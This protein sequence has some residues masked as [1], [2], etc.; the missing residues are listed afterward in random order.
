[1]TCKRDFG[2]VIASAVSEIAQEL[3]NAPEPPSGEGSERHLRTLLRDH[4]LV[5]E[6]GWPSNQILYGELYDIYGHD[7]L[8]YVVVYVETKTPRRSRL[9]AE[10][11]LDFEARMKRLGTCEY[12]MITNGHQLISYEVSLV[13]SKIVVQR[14]CEVDLD[15]VVEQVRNGDLSIENRDKLEQAFEQLRPEKYLKKSPESYVDEYGRINPVKSEKNSMKALSSQLSSAIDVLSPV[16]AE[17]LRVYL[18]SKIQ[19]GLG[20]QA[21]EPLDDWSTY[22]GRVPPST[23]EK[24]VEESVKEL[25]ALRAKGRINDVVL[26][27]KERDAR[28]KLGLAISSSSWSKL[29]ADSVASPEQVQEII[30]NSVLDLI[31]EDH[32]EVFA[33][34][35]SHV[36]LSRILLYRVAEDKGLVERKLSGR[37]LDS[38]LASTGSGLLDRTKKAT[39]IKVLVEEAEELL[40]SVFYSDLYLHGLF[41]WWVVP[42]EVREKYS[43]QYRSIYQRTSRS[44][45]V[46]LE[47]TIRILNRFRLDS[48]ERDVWKD[49]YQE[50]LPAK[51]RAKLGGFYTPDEVVNLI[52][53]LVGYLPQSPICG[54]TLLDPACGSGTFVV[55][56]GNR[57]RAHLESDCECHREISSVREPRKRA[58]LI[59]QKMIS[60]LYALDIHPFACF[61]TEMNFVLSTVDLLMNARQLDL[62][63]RIEELNVGCDDSLRPAERHIHQLKLSQFAST[64]SRAQ[65]LIRDRRKA[66]AIKEAS[67]D[68]VVGNPPWSGV[69][70]GE[71]SPLFDEAT[72]QLYKT[73]YVSATDKYDLYVLFVERGIRWLNRNGRLGLI[74]QN[75]FARRR[76]GRGLRSLIKEKSGSLLYCIDMART[77]KVVFPGQT[78][79]PW[80]TVLQMNRGNND[81]LFAETKKPLFKLTLDELVSEIKHGLEQAE[82]NQLYESDKI[83][84]YPLPQTRIRGNPEE[85]W[86][87]SSSGASE[88]K[89]KIRSTRKSHH[90]SQVLELNQG[91]T[92]GGGCLDVFLTKSPGSFEPELVFPCA[93]A[94]DIVCWKL[95]EPHKWIVYPYRKDGSSVNLG[96]I[97]LDL[98]QDQAHAEIDGLIAR[99]SIKYPKVAKFLVDRY[100][101]LAS[102]EAEKMSWKDYGKAW[103]EYHRPRSPSLMMESPKILTRRMTHDMEF[104]LDDRGFIPTDGCIALTLTKNSNWIESMREQGFDDRDSLCFCLALLNSE[105]VKFLVRNSADSW[106]GEYYQVREDT[107]ADVPVK[108]PSKVDKAMF[109]GVIAAVKGVLEGKE[110]PKA[111]NSEILRLYG[112]EGAL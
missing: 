77:G 65:L 99:G 41:D 101:K 34:Q 103:Y 46:A 4:L 70:R 112:L 63:F 59:L 64:N 98:S 58:K 45:D 38:Y 79:Y 111:A 105:I 87:M 49:V 7:L 72:K 56:A 14:I 75:R 2:E 35:T 30:E 90:L 83:V 36:I 44:I 17:T 9:T 106:Q 109:E 86:D 37:P 91:V 67:F 82:R 53:D 8:G 73:L 29:I 84:A 23:I 19:I 27:R 15:Q 20:F 94:E 55:E 88:L 107:L 39:A 57:L 80:I 68:L 81:F 95:G 16:L 71:L 33:R 32:I 5:T 97:S 43:D 85:P 3:K 42:K 22:S 92:P 12:G 74:T 108:N 11:V 78:N 89:K 50:Y 26:R 18:A 24:Y 48:I 61:L 52:L 104:C 40:A 6:L 62:A 21:V 96:R 25:L 28:R 76:Y 102:R 60:N 47:E 69:L 54:C 100:S 93:E 31:S 1:V 66:K 110:E 13:R 10:E 51:E